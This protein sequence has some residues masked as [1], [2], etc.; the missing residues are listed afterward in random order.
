MIP[1]SGAAA[2]TAAMRN[3]NLTPE[4][5]SLITRSR[6][7]TEA[8]LRRIASEPRWAAEYQVKAGLVRN[9]R[10]PRAAT[11][12]MVKHL[13][14]RDLALVSDDVR[15]GPPLRRLAEKNL[16]DRLPELAVGER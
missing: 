12:S 5:V 2:L 8:L 15:L 16:L 13:F 4:H 1:N 3:P 10:A 11:M 14:W 9:P 7:A 6:S